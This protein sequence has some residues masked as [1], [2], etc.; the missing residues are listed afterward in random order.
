MP[1][2]RIAHI[3]KVLIRT[4]RPESCTISHYDQYIDSKPSYGW[5]RSQTRQCDVVIARIRLGYRMNWQLHSARSADES[6]YRLCNEETKRML[7]DPISEYHVIQPFRPPNM[8]YKELCEYFIYLIHWK[9]YLYSILNLL[10]KTAVNKEH[11]YV[12]TVAKAYQRNI[13]F[14][15]CMIYILILLWTITVVTEYCTMSNICK[16]VITIAHA[17]SDIQGGK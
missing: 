16:T 11:C 8:R 2:A 4:S 17:W 12:N 3:L 13:F 9:I 14:V 6:R 10:C 5:H 15:W 1:L 7:E